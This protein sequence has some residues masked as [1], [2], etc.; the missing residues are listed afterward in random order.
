[1]SGG[2]LLAFGWTNEVTD[3]RPVKFVDGIADAAELLTEFVPPNFDQVGMYWD[4]TVE[5]IRMA[6]PG[7]LRG[8]SFRLLGF[9]KR[10]QEPDALLLRA[11]RDGH[12]S[13]AQ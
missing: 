8:R 11:R 3:M 2:I 1:M 10:N 4:A 9:M 5:A 12:P 13:G 7:H 6:F